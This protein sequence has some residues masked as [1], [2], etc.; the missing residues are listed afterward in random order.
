MLPLPPGNDTEAVL[1]AISQMENNVALDFAK[2][3]HIHPQ[4]A[5]C[6]MERFVSI[7]E[8]MIRYT[9]KHSPAYWRMIR[10]DNI[11]G[12]RR[13]E[14][15]KTTRFEAA[16]HIRVG[17][18]LFSLSS[19]STNGFQCWSGIFGRTA[20][21]LFASTMAG[22][23]IKEGWT[24]SD[25]KISIEKKSSSYRN[26]DA[27]GTDIRCVLRV[28]V[29]DDQIGGLLRFPADR[30]LCPLPDLDYVADA[31]ERWYPNAKGV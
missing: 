31:I 26:P 3:F 27:Y 21:L 24:P 4:G 15:V 17:K 14:T 5:E 10:D 30:E 23:M 18:E 1:F 16:A 9:P 28:Y 12:N 19:G 22:V 11:G 6:W 8:R 13:V 29:P 7:A 20:S 2:A 25:N